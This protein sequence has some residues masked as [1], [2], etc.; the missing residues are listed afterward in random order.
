MLN[1]QKKEVVGFEE[2]AHIFLSMQDEEK[3]EQPISADVERLDTTSN[4]RF[5][6]FVGSIHAKKKSFFL[7]QI[8][9]EL[10][11]IRCFQS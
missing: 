10:I 9:I 7:K 4:V 6:P 1:R 5:I 2:I 11:T 3:C 8:C